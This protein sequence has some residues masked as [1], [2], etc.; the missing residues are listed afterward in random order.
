[1]GLPH[2]APNARM[3]FP[4]ILDQKN[5]D[6]LHGVNF[7]SRSQKRKN[8]EVPNIAIKQWSSG[9]GR[10]HEPETRVFSTGL[11]VPMTKKQMGFSPIP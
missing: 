5:E 9:W 1:M 10:L 11:G 2:A 7:K 3:M 4:W 8:Y 6:G